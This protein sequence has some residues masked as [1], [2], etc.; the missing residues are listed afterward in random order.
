MHGKMRAESTG[1]R[2]GNARIF[3]KKHNTVSHRTP[4]LYV[5]NGLRQR[6]TKAAGWLGKTTTPQTAS[7]ILESLQ[8]T[9]GSAPF[10]SAA[11]MVRLGASRSFSAESQLFLLPVPVP[12]GMRKKA[13]CPLRT[14]SETSLKGLLPFPVPE[15]FAPVAGGTLQT[16]PTGI[17]S[18]LILMQ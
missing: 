14:V 1:N 15:Q 10:R 9:G 13:A 18:V 2:P 5:V 7:L 6:S 12:S 4:D 11:R 17:R 8:L 3:F 16:W